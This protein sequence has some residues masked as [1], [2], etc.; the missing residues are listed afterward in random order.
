MIRSRQNKDYIWI[1]ETL[2]A[3]NKQDMNQK[4][5]PIACIYFAISLSNMIM[6]KNRPRKYCPCSTIIK[7]RARSKRSWLSCRVSIPATGKKMNM[8]WTNRSEA[9]VCSRLPQKR[10]IEIW[11]L[12]LLQ[13]GRCTWKSRKARIRGKD[14]QRQRCDE[15]PK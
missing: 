14:H 1:N 5:L 13:R 6:V 8:P 12:W 15:V 3:K 2:F 4:N 9:K 7:T 11:N 10:A